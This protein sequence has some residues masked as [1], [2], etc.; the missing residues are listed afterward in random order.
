MV[1]KQRRRWRT[2]E[3]REEGMAVAKGREEDLWRRDG[4]EMGRGRWW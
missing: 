2:C 3:A 4:E 1:V